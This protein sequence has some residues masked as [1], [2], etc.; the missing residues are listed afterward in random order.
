MSHI[1]KSQHYVWKH[2]LKPWTTNG[3]VN[4][5]RDGKPFKTSPDNIAQQNYFYK[6]NPINIEEIEFAQY[7][8][9]KL[10]PTAKESLSNLLRLYYITANTDDYLMK[11]GIED[12]HGIVE[13][14][15]I[16]L[17]AKLYKVDLSFMER[18]KEK[19]DFSFFIGCQYSRTNN[20]RSRLTNS[21]ITI[22]ENV[23]KE[24]FAKIFS[25]F[26]AA[27]IGN[28]VYSKARLQFLNNLTSEH[29]ITSDQPVFNLKGTGS[30]EIE[31][32]EFELFYPISP[33]Q[34]IILSENNI[35]PLIEIEDVKKAKWFNRKIHQN[36]KEQIY[37]KNEE[38]LIIK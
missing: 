28:W 30:T 32:S 36:A 9:G 12:F 22:P 15:F 19:N 11:C 5:F 24:N 3:Q 34:A 10:D 1:K 23:N 17:L 33:T 29:F 20:M 8:I 13:T 2:Y 26:M 27:I 7:Y 38:D 4:C 6:S 21:K 14:N 35:Q 16:P 37:A 31:P 18:I 25:L